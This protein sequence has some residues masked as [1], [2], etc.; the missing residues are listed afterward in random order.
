M[1][2]KIIGIAKKKIEKYTTIIK[3]AG[4]GTRFLP[5]ICFLVCSFLQIHYTIF[6]FVLYFQ[7]LIVFP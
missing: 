3:A 5:P 7:K 2:I 4:L 1:K 6:I